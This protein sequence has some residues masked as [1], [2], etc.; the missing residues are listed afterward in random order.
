MLARRGGLED[1]AQTQQT[2]H[3]E[4]LSEGSPGGPGDEN[5]PANAG[6]TGSIPGP[7]EST[8]HTAT[9]S[10]ITTAEKRV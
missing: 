10:M 6:G 4:G 5:L 7:G 3:L 2:S 9:R 1:A 8:C